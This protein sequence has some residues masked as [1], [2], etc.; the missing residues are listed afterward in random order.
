MKG[1]HDGVIRLGLGLLF[2]AY[3]VHEVWN[4]ICEKA[5]TQKQKQE[6][7]NKEKDKNKTRQMHCTKM[8]C[9]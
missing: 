1:L 3:I 8:F 6:E 5:A 7:E 4:S 2:T 9:R